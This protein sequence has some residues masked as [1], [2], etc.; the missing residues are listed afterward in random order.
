MPELAIL[1]V[2]AAV[3]A[4]AAVSGR[5]TRLSLTEPL[6]AVS[7]GVV[8][9]A[10]LMEPV[11]LRHPVVLTFLELTLA[12]VLFT[13][14]ARIDLGR[15]RA[16]YQWPLRMLVIGLPLAM[17]AGALAAGWLL[18]LP[19]GL[20]L[21]VGVTLAPT[22]AA[23]ALPLLE[24]EELPPRIRQSVNV[25]S[26][27][28]D[29]LALP[30]LFIAIG[31]IG[32]E[33]GRSAG[34]AL[35]LIIEQIGIGVVGG[36]LFGL[37]GAWVIGEGGRRGWM[38]PIHQKIAGV[39][40]ALAAF[41]AVQLLGGSG[42]VAAFVAGAVLGA[43]LRPRGEYLYE[44]AEAEGRALVLVA[45]LIIGAGPVYELL[46]VG[47]PWEVWVVAVASL[48]IVRPLAIAL[49][50]IG[51][52]L[53]ASTVAFLG[54]FGPRGLAT[55]VFLLIAEEE[56]LAVPPGVVGVVVVTVALSVVLH[57][58]TARPASVW[59]AKRIAATSHEEMPEVGE[60]FDHP[61]R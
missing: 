2:A 13:D 53:R 27:L 37:L 15:L 54:W 3:L 11:D 39:A 52:N 33:E 57:G 17:V 21:L 38:T 46:Q 14:A 30:A 7:L 49:S 20:A 22:D 55:F 61:M 50:L 12:L 44:F 6:V 16:Q 41:A 51:Q 1:V 59:L 34:A 26:G 48:V 10:L 58:V 43:R 56:L 4:I 42:F 31:L 40:L 35:L 25:E 23:L 18:A 24:S 36:V 60:A 19:V 29:G 9:T 45:F 28:N 8:I 47:A 5:L 32:S